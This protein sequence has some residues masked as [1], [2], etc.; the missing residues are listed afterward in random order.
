M[1]RGTSTTICHPPRVPFLQTTRNAHC[2]DWKLH[3]NVF[4]VEATSTLHCRY[5]KM[6]ER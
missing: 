2:L 4:E 6:L 5:V 1:A 3:G